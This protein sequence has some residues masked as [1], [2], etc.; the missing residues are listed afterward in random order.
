MRIVVAMTTCD[1]GPFLQPQLDSIVAQVR[2]PDALIVSDDASTDGSLDLLRAFAASSTF[3]VTVLRNAS[4]SG[5]HRNS[6]KALS[7]AAKIGDVVVLAA[8]DDLWAPE[9]LD[10]VNE[11][12][13][14]RPDVSLWFSDADLIDAADRSL[15][16]K[17]SDLVTLR[18]SDLAEFREGGGIGR[19]IHGGTISGPTL[20]VRS[21]VITAAALPFPEESDVR[22]PYFYEDAWMALVA[23]LLGEF[24]TDDRCL[25]HYR[26]HPGQLSAPRSVVETDRAWRKERREARM[27]DRVATG[28][29]ASRIRDRPQ[30]AWIPGRAEEVLALDSFLAARTMPRGAAGRWR[31]LLLQLNRGSYSRFARG[32]RTFAADLL[33]L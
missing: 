31:A 8:H 11:A 3:P 13:A 27:R 10:A 15:G 17:L 1:S 24:A 9:K 5:L 30:I 4:R 16:T 20:A 12:F 22:I 26:R 25:V 29:I 23:R 19:L 2:A 6:A 28:L 32:L 33:D 18:E 14:G 21:D 7:E